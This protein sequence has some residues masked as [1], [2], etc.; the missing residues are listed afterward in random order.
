MA[1]GAS[2]NC[3]LAQHLS[4]HSGGRANQRRVAIKEKKESTAS[5]E[6]Q[7]EDLHNLSV[8]WHSMHRDLAYI[9]QHTDKLLVLQ[10]KVET[11]M[12][13]KKCTPQARHV[14]GESTA[15][16]NVRHLED[17]RRFLVCFVKSYIERTNIHI[18][19][20]SC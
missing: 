20:V 13:E 8:K 4:G 19:L 7:A 16:D 15:A 11:T 10:D 12:S 3:E 6:K 1:Q 17:V 9:Q 18:Q 5:V 14:D 2:S